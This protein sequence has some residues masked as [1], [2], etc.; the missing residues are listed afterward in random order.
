MAHHSIIYGRINGATWK[1]KDYNKLHRL[2]LDVISS[3]PEKDTEFP[4]IN[5]SMFSVP[6]EQG[7]FRD[8]V[9]TFGASYKTLET[10]W[11]LW[12]EKFES[13]IKR[14]YWFDITIHAEFEVMG[15]YKYD[16]LIDVNQMESWHKEYPKTIL[17]WKFESNGPRSFMNEQKN[18]PI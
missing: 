14:L 16:W 12:I 2:N 9:I 3:L 18:T 8:Q 11:H 7:T 15:D 17:D 5:R 4:W 1:T 13:L 6:N 10:E